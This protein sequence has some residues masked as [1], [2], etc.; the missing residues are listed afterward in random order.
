MNWN[1]ISLGQY[2]QIAT[3]KASGINLLSIATSKDV[4]ELEELTPSQLLKLSDVY[5]FLNHEPNAVFVTK[6]DGY[7]V[8][9]FKSPKTG[10]NAIDF[11]ALIEDKEH[12]FEN[13]DRILAVILTNGKEEDFDIKR[14]YIADNM[15]ITIAFGIA[16]FFLTNF[17]ISQKTIPYYLE[18]VKRGRVNPIVLANRIQGMN[19]S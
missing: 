15:P 6:W 11:L 10:A 8:L 2:Q 1:D 17:G 7:N 14:K 12:Y 3:T 13:L 16:G 9:D 5:E 18:Q 4:D 19:F